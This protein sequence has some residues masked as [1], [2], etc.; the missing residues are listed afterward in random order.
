MKGKF[1]QGRRLRAWREFVGERMGRKLTLKAAAE[2]IA[3][4][5]E[6][7]GGDRNCRWVPC[8]H[9]SLTRWELGN[10]Q[11]NI[12]GL[13]IIAKAYGVSPIDLMGMP[14]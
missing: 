7:Q 10:V 8:T 5:V 6:S 2:L 12:Q 14:T 9:A 3:T 1:E 11:H 13:G 4:E